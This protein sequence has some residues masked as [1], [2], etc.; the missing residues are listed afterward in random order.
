MKASKPARV[1]GYENRTENST[2]DKEI[3]TTTVVLFF[4][5]NQGGWFQSFWY[6]STRPSRMQINY[7]T[8]HPVGYRPLSD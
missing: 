7:A 2:N 8:N 4:E 3:T 6:T 1:V 5:T